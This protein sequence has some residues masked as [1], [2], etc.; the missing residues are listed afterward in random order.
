MIRIRAILRMPLTTAIAATAVL[1]LIVVGMPAATTGAYLTAD[2]T[3]TGATG[4]GNWCSVPNPAVSKNVYKLSDF[5]AINA[6]EASNNGTT[7]SVRMLVL[8]V[9]NDGSFDPIEALPAQV[10]AADNQLGVRLW[11][12]TPSMSETQSIKLTAWRGNYA[13][14]NANTFA[15]DVMPTASVSFAEARLT[16]T[17][18][19]SVNTATSSSTF[20]G[21]ELR[22]LHRNINR[23]G[24]VTGGTDPVTM[25]YSWMLTT[26]R[27]EG[28]GY[29]SDPACAN[30]TC[31]V[32]GAGGVT[33]YNTVFSGVDTAAAANA[34]SKNSTTYLAEKYYAASGAWPTTTA[35]QDQLQCS[36]RYRSN[37][38]SQW[39]GWSEYVDTA[40]TSC[41][42]D[43]N[44]IDYRSRTVQE[45][46]TV[47][48]EPTATPTVIA[49]RGTSTIDSVLRDTTGTK[50]QY[51]VLEWWG[52]GTPPADL[53]IEVF[54]A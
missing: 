38:G 18:N 37:P 10:P 14:P 34:V 52:T 44:R 32:D 54:V 41:P 48:A 25:R 19:L 31:H 46:V 49:P 2:D 47:D 27:S 9:V 22:D 26:G 15:W 43:T 13:A 12:C 20:P 5:T 6:P 7:S 1:T 39:S 40:G 29:T 21:V 16:S 35:T 24:G 4:I 11:S 28:A 3:T 17:S 8:P 36:Y 42:D 53:E 51:V 33:N 45:T 30:K 50:V 23:L